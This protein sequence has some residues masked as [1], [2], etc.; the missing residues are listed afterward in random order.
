MATLKE[1]YEAALNDANDARNERDA[2][3]AQIKSDSEKHA[4][5]LASK[6]GSYTYISKQLADVKEELDA[7]HSVL[8]ALPNVPKR[9]IQG[10]N[11]WEKTKLSVTARLC[12]YFAAAK[13]ATF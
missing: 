6:D 9:E 13:T 2:A 11:S 12:A 8:D 7:L 4:K 1:K 3:W 5:E 10:E